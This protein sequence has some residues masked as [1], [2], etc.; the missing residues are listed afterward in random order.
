MYNLLFEFSLH[1]L[2]DLLFLCVGLCTWVFSPYFFYLLTLSIRFF[3]SYRRLFGSRW[4]YIWSCL[5]LFLLQCLFLLQFFLLLFVLSNSI[6]HR[7]INFSHYQVTSSILINFLLFV[8]H[9]SRRMKRCD[10]VKWVE[11][12]NWVRWVELCDVWIRFRLRVLVCWCCFW[13]FNLLIDVCFLN[14]GLF[15]LLFH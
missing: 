8:N 1:E 13:L 15:T 9:F 11:W 7:L 4:I 6:I 14:N 12:C 2:I 5:L 3:F 10:W